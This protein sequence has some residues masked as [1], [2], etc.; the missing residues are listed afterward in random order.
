MS[1]IWFD[2]NDWMIVYCITSLSKI[3]PSWIWRW[4]HCRG[5]AAKFTPL[6]GAYGLWAGRDLYRAIPTMTQD[7]GFY[8]PISKGPPMLSGLLRW[9]RGSFLTGIPTG[10]EIHIKNS[11]VILIW[12]HGFQIMGDSRRFI[13]VS[14]L[15]NS[16]VTKIN[17]KKFSHWSKASL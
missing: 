13:T 1:N 7:I 2:R 11:H 10:S 8:G 15:Y 17:Y 4:R 9:Y 6:L 14:M 12:L 5:R 16:F 3:L